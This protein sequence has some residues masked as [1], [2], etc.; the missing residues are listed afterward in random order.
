MVNLDT[1]ESLDA[2]TEVDPDV[3]RAHGLVPKRGLVKVLGRGEL[4][5]ALTV[6][7]H[8]FSQGA[9]SRPSRRRAAGSRSSRPVGRRASAGP[10]QRADQPISSHAPARL[11]AFSFPNLRR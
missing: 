8:G 2:G 9:I 5:K 4:T 1:L 7:A 11:R 3:L 10:W 6:R